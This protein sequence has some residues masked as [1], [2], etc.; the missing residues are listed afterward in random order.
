MTENQIIKTE[1]TEVK[2]QEIPQELIDEMR[3]MD[4]EEFAKRLASIAHYGYGTIF[5]RYAGRE[6]SK[7]ELIDDDEIP[8]KRKEIETEK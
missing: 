1:V 7:P 5:E 3:E 8:I 6:N 4:D 2:F